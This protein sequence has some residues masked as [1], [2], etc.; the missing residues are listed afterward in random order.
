MAPQD[1]NIVSNFRSMACVPADKPLGRGG[2]STFAEKQGL[3]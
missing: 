3:K 1:T 2:N